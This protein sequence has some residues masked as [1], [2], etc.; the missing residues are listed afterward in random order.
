MESERMLEFRQQYAQSYKKYSEFCDTLFILFGKLLDNNGFQYQFVSTRVKEEESLINKLLTV[1]ALSEINRISELDDIAG[2]RIIFYLDSEIQKFIQYIYQEFDVV[3][4]N[5]KYSADDYNAHHFVIKLKE[6]RL[7]LTEYAQFKEMKCELQL[8]TVLYHAW[9]EVAHNITYKSSKELV[10]FN[11]DRMEF[12]KTEF[13]TIMKDYI[14]PANYKFEFI[15]TEYLELLKGKEIFQNVFFEEILTSNSLRDI[16]LKLSLLGQY[17]EKY[18][19]KTPSDYDLID[20][21]KEILEKSKG[22]KIN[23][24]ELSSN[25]NDYFYVVEQ[26]LEILN[27]VKYQYIERVFPILIE[28]ALNTDNRI[29]KLGVVAIKKL[30]EY[31]SGVLKQIGLKLQFYIIDQIKKWD[32][33]EKLLRINIINEVFIEVFQLDFEIIDSID[34]KTMG[35]SSGL[36]LAEEPLK[37]LRKQSM[38]LLMELYFVTNEIPL[39]IVILDVLKE[40]T[41]TPNRGVYSEEI[42]NLVVENTISLIDWYITIANGDAKLEIIKKIDEQ[43]NWF[44]R[45]YLSSIDKI[46]ELRRIIENNEKY[47]I[48]KDLVGYD[49]DYLEDMDWRTAKTI[50]NKRNEYHLKNI[51]GDNKVFWIEL[52]I[53]ICNGAEFTEQGK[54]TYFNKFLYE[55]SKENRNFAKELILHLE[56]DYKR[57]LHHILAGLSIS[58][59]DY[60]DRLIGQWIEEGRNLISCI[61][62]F[63]YKEKVEL[64]ILNCIFEKAALKKE[65]NV[66]A[67]IVRILNTSKINKAKGKVLFI[68]TIQ[69]LSKNNIHWWIQYVWF[70]EESIF[71]YF[72]ELEQDQLIEVLTTCPQIEYHIEEILIPIAKNNPLKV[73]KFFE[74]RL[75][76]QDAKR[77]LSL[78]YE[79]I[80]YHLHKVGEI[81]KE[82]SKIVIPEIL[83]WFKRDFWFYSYEASDL[84]HDIFPSFDEPLESFLRTFLDEKDEIGAK[85]ILE[86]L[87]KYDGDSSIFPFCQEFVITYKDNENL[88]NRL[89]EVLS[90]TGVVSGE[91]GSVKALQNTKSLIRKWNKSKSEPLK[92]FAKDFIDSLNSKIT[93]ETKR[94]DKYVQLM[95]YLYGESSE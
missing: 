77:N 45:R 24:D 53:E 5:L 32:N 54:Y 13:K 95:Q 79:A 33:T 7:N 4:N 36:L 38:E 21:I 15:N 41:K 90:R 63:L 81:L 43:A 48:Y 39:K 57:S 25:D 67:E 69:E 70:D 40:V 92:S 73:I 11:K 51:S 19:D 46:S 22:L 58:D 60:A 35:I 31:K 12:F 62:S 18:G 61:L 68:K 89:M 55:I 56:K 78:K 20:F 76:I 52:I 59:V 14:K 91:Y 8:T 80:P 44:H 88:L 3:K 85:I 66:L 28:L 47:K 9:S 83:D 2:C 37:R 1:K 16:Y 74:T 10:D 50:R 65:N 75:L 94:S 72:D 34:Y 26:C 17:I 93:H 84:L 64:N 87:E 30:T 86:V 49:F 27:A 82:H 42:E 29:N 23:I 71:N 6:D